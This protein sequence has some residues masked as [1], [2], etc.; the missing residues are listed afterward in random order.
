MPERAGNRCD[1]CP[2]RRRIGRRV[3]QT[4]AMDEVG[5]HAGGTGPG[6]EPEELA[7]SPEEPR[8]RLDLAAEELTAA[9]YEAERETGVREETAE[10]VRRSLVLRGVRMVGGFVLIGVGVSLLVLPGPGWIM[11]IIGLSLLPFAWAERAIRAIRRKV[12][13]VPE[14]GTIPPTTWFIIGVVT[15]SAI[16]I[17]F[18]FGEQIGSWIGDTWSSIWS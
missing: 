11:I 1:V 2:A 10:D 12:P 14:D 16:V 13:G 17:S 3:L 18:L 7:D 9:A 6:E 5:E 4:V 15:V 8:S